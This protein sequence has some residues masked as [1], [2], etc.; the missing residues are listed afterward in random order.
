MEYG[1]PGT[2]IFLTCIVSDP[3][4]LRPRRGESGVCTE[5]VVKG[6]S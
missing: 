4:A 2:L 1:S 6:W 5:G 3:Q